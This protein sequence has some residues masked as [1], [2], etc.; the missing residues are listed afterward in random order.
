M[1]PACRPLLV[2][3]VFILVLDGLRRPGIGSEELF[4][5]GVLP[6]P[7]FPHLYSPTAADIS[8]QAQ[9]LPPSPLSKV[10]CTLLLASPYPPDPTHPIS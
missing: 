5:G 1:S 8:F 6:P 3:L 7:P 9:G 4:Q 2:G 10:P